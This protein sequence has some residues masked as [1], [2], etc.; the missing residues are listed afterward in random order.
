MKYIHTYIKYIQNIYIY[1]YIYGKYT[2]KVRRK[3]GTWISKITRGN[4]RPLENI[5]RGW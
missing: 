2:R 3:L 5:G 4:A 1:I